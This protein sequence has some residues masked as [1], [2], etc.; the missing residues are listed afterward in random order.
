MKSD[1]LFFLI[2]GAGSALDLVK[3]SIEE[4]VA[5]HTAAWE[6]V[7][8]VGGTG[9]FSYHDGSIAGVSFKGALP[10]GWKAK[11]NNGSSY[12]RRGSML[13]EEIVALPKVKIDSFR[14]A[15][16]LSIPLDLV[17]LGEDGQRCGVSC[18]SAPFNEC[19]FA[20]ESGDG[21]YLLWIH[22]VPGA[23]KRAQEDTR[24]P[25]TLDPKLAAYEPAFDGCRQIVKEEWDFIVAKARLEKAGK[26][27]PA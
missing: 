10:K 9:L 25:R 4:R 12:P 23:V 22:D 24:R 15:K 7:E 1:K 27:V 21:P 26:A 2:E 5:A 20:Y 14:I 13:Y 6:F 8:K 17:W 18:I 3:A 11:A 19:G 16:E